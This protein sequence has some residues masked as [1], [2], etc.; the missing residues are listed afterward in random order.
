MP[1]AEITITP[2]RPGD[3]GSI[4]AQRARLDAAFAMETTDQS[5]SQPGVHGYLLVLRFAIINLVAFVLLGGAYLQG[6]VHMVISADSTGLTFAIFAALAEAT[7]IAASV[8]E[9]E[10]IFLWLQIDGV[11]EPRA[12]TLPWSRRAAE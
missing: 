7:V 4:G 10:A 1:G 3:D 5:A 2:I 11:D 8:R 6:W 12:Y 9:E